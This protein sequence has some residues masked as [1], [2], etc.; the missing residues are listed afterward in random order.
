[1]V[2]IIAAAGGGYAIHGGYTPLYYSDKKI[3]REHTR[4]FWEFIRFKSFDQAAEYDDDEDK[5]T[6]A[7]VPKMFDGFPVK[8][9]VSGEFE[10]Y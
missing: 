9:L 6:T 10:A 8:T 4:Q 7:K 1:M 3:I 5:E 2:V